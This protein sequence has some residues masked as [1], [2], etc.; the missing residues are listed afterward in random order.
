MRSRQAPSALLRPTAAR[1]SE[2]G[3]AAVALRP[4]EALWL[5]GT[6]LFMALAWAAL[7][8]AHLGVLSVAAVAAGAAV[9]ALA[10]LLVVRAGGRRVVVAGPWREAAALGALAGLLALLYLPGFPYG[11]ADK[12]PGVYVA[13][14]FAIARGGDV[15]LHDEVLARLPDVTRWDEQS[16]FPG[17]YP[18]GDRPEVIAQFYHLYPATMA[19]LGRLAGQSAMVDL[20]PLL[21]IGSALG[22]Y[23]VGRRVA[24]PLAGAVA[25]AVLAVNMIQVWQAKYP[26][27]E[28]STQLLLLLATLAVMIAIQERWWPAAACAGLALGVAWL[29]RADV[30]APVLLALAVLACAFALGRFRRR[31]LAFLAGLALV[32]P[33]ALW[34]AFGTAAVY[35]RL[36]SGWTPPRLALTAGV[37]VAAAA[38]GRLA[39]RSP[40]GRRLERVAGRLVADGRPRLPLALLPPALLAAGALL[41]WFRPQ[42]FG[43]DHFTYDGRV[44]RSYDEINLRRLAWFVTIPGVLAA[45]AG[46]TLLCLRRWRAATWV[47]VGPALLALAAYVHS[48]INS[49]RLMW[50]ARRYVPLGLGVLALLVGVA[51]A[52]A[53]VWRGRAALLVRLAGAAV[54]VVVIGTGLAQ[55]VAI[56]RHREYDGSFA[57]TARIASAAGGRPAVLAW[58]WPRVHGDPTPLFATSTWFQRGQP[59]V[60]LPRDPGPADLER[61]RRAF[62]GRRL[63]VVGNRLGLP[64][65]LRA[66]GLRRVDAF[67]LRLPFWEQSV[68]SRPTH[69]AGL[70][71]EVLVWEA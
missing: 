42:L 18:V 68:T 10:L 63:L 2:P 19:F 3:P 60:L 64:E 15:R 52:A 65:R 38:A 45:L 67:S 16:R 33:H 8:T 32:A 37:L 47:A 62:P 21:A 13:H 49:A 1:T 34:Q 30:L 4:A 26:S 53:L 12:D 54:A 29:D 48:A 71:V 5:A 31:H 17:V 24:G 66:V 58:T 11:A 51:V 46:F 61:I 56:A 57:A 69:D 6:C 23:L 14:A 9:V 40:L 44:V 35:T 7:A 20:N 55:S 39:W 41:A 27:S 36:A 28:V 59:A 25:A 22:L 50:W 43:I 70:P